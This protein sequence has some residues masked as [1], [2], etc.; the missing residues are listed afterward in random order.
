MTGTRQRGVNR[1][2]YTDLDGSLIDHYTY[3]YEVAQP[4]VRKLNAAGI[5]LVF[6][7]SKTRAEQ[8]VYRRGLGVTGPFIAE[9][10]GAIFIPR[11]YFNFPYEYQREVGGYKVIELARPYAEIRQKLEVIREKY[12]LSLRGYGDMDT[13]EVARITGLD[14]AQAGLA[15][16]RE[17]QETL[18]LTGSEEEIE[19][20]LTHITEAG[21]GYS[22]G[23]RFYGVMAGSDKGRAVRMLTAMFRQKLG[24]VE[25]I[26]VGDSGND[27]PMLAAVDW[28]VLVQKPGSLWQEMALAKLYRA[29]GIGPQGWVK[30]IA[31]L[32]GI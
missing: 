10:G 2:I 22:R 3:S 27:M 11:G 23:G 29:E 6:V 14:M 30:A 19:V 17:Y 25:T 26:G 13:A 31:E 32:T 12:G 5:P 1:V 28:P 8:E 7:S 21:L 16:K 9:N 20:A 18:N 15:K 4:L 24:R